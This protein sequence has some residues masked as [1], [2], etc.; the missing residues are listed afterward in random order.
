MIR[1]RLAELL[2]ERQLK[3]SRVANEIPNLSRNTITSTAQNSGK[4]IQLETINSL[5]KY[6]GITPGEFFEYIPYDLE[7]SIDDIKMDGQRDDYD[8]PLT[9]DEGKMTFT[10]F[11]KLLGKSTQQYTYEYNVTNITRFTMAEGFSLLLDFK[12]NI[13]R[14]SFSYFWKDT[15]TPGFQ[16]IIQESIKEEISDSLLNFDNNNSP[17]KR[18]AI[19]MRSNFY[20]DGDFDSQLKTYTDTTRGYN[21]ADFFDSTHNLPF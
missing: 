9:V 17:A 3:I 8:Q 19:L 2:S 7:L 4:M 5:C 10:L 15:I 12:E 21:S 6:L 18:L 1:N 11:I 14:Y 20:T 16:A 13:D